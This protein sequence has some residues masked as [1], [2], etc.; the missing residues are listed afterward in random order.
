MC[1]RDRKI[2][3]AIRW[4]GDGLGVLLAVLGVALLF[5]AN[6]PLF[7][8]FVLLLAGLSIGG[9]RLLCWIV[10]GFA[11]PKSPGG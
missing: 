7:G 11:E 4:I 9:G 3:T 1:I 8:I 2:A 6:D 5:L 10:N